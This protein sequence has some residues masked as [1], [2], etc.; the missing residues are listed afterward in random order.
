MAPPWRH[1]GHAMQYTVG[2]LDGGP[3]AGKEK[4]GHS[5]TGWEERGVGTDGGDI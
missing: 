1:R 5:G 2:A 3:H 4:V